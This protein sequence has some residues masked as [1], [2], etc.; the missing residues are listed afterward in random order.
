MYWLLISLFIWVLTSFINVD[1]HYIHYSNNNTEYSYYW[2]DNYKDYARMQRLEACERK[3]I[4][5]LKKSNQKRTIHCATMM[6]L[7]TAYESWYMKSNRCVNQKNCM[8]LKGRRWNGSYWFLT[9]KNH[10]DWNI[11]FADKWF[12]YHYKKSIHTL[13]YGYKQNDWSY[14]Y[15]W[16]TTDQV[17]Y[18]AFIKDKYS[19]VYNELHNLIK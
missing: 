17:T 18:V 8:W 3:Q 19:L 10:Y 9:F 14:K 7:I 11:Y 2:V 5:I 1:A 6:T 12:I 4:E 15:W 16:S 13:I